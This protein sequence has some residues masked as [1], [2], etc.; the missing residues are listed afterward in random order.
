[1]ELSTLAAL[2]ER[3]TVQAGR[4]QTLALAKLLNRQSALLL[5]RHNLSPGTLAASL[6]NYLIHR[7]LQ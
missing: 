3:G 6:P 2:D 5:A 4:L 1:M 7:V